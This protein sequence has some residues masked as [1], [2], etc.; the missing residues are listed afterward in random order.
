MKPGKKK[1]KKK[2]GTEGNT[3]HLDEE[4]GLDTPGGLALAISSGPTEGVNLVNKD[5]GGLVFAGHFKQVLHKPAKGRDEKEGGGDERK[6]AT[7]NSRK[8]GPDLSLSPIHFETR[9]AEDTDIKVELASVATA[10]A[11]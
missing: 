4:L 6:R 11:R 5:D 7:G 1:K 8:A 3:V 9:S 2:G 10:L